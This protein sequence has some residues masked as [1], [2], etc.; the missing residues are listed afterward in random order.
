METRRSVLQH[1]IPEL[2]SSNLIEEYL[3]SLSNTSKKK[4]EEFEISPL[5]K[6]LWGSVKPLPE[7]QDY[8]DV[9]AEEIIKKH[10]K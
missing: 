5:V 2:P 7:S 9:L 1:N 6:S 4:E 10:I 8:K 3:K